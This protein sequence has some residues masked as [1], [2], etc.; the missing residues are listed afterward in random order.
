[1]FAVMV[2]LTSLP[3]RRVLVVD[4]QDDERALLRAWEADQSPPQTWDMSWVDR[5]TA[6]AG[7]DLI[8]RGGFQYGDWLD[9]TAPAEDPAAPPQ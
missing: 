7:D 8:W 5:V 4:D 1:M 3:G 2:D 9:P 6:L